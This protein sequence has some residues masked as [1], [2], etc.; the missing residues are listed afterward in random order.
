MQIKATYLSQSFIWLF[1]SVLVNLI[2]TASTQEASP[3]GG[4]WLYLQTPDFLTFASAPS[5]RTLDVELQGE[6]TFEMWFYVRSMSGINSLIFGKDGDFGVEGSYQFKQWDF[7][8]TEVATGRRF[9]WYFFMSGSKGPGEELAPAA[10][11]GETKPSLN[12]WHHVAF[13]IVEPG[14]EDG[15]ILFLDGKAETRFHALPI[16]PSRSKFYFMGGTGIDMAV[17]EARISNIARYRS[18]F[19]PPYE[20]L[21]PDKHT[22]ALWH[23]DERADATVFADASGNGNT[24]TG[25]NGARI[26]RGKGKLTPPQAVHPR[27]KIVLT[28]GDIKSRMEK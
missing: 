17:E 12:E 28:W 23:F 24:L 16:R 1:L 14:R 18:N 15:G 11:F 2:S 5:N 6:A 25:H 13:V 19:Q 26:V 3:T 7:I 8:V 22:M 10:Y 27:T 9:A 21:E 4:G 20:P